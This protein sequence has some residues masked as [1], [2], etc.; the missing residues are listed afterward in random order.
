MKVADIVLQIINPMP[1]M[2]TSASLLNWQIAYL[3]AQQTSSFAS[4]APCDGDNCV[5]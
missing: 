5:S 2:T 3:G 1:K 4:F